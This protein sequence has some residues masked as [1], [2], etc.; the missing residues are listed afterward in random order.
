MY[1]IQLVLFVKCN[2]VNNNVERSLWPWLSL[3]EMNFVNRHCYCQFLMKS[4]YLQGKAVK[5]DIYGMHLLCNQNM[6]RADCFLQDKT[7]LDNACSLS[8]RGLYN[9]LI[10][11]SLGLK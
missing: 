8:V 4:F 5:N 11:R 10:A 6:D 1:I 2:N 3:V 7:K 9:Y